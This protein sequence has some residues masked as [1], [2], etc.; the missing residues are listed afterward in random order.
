MKTTC[1]CSG[2][3]ALLF[4][5]LVQAGPS[6]TD[7]MGRQVSLEAPAERIVALAPHIVENLYSAGAGDR[8][9]GVVS[10]SDF[11]AA[12]RSLP[13]VGS[14]FA[15]SLETV[16]ALQPDLV[17]LWGSGN[18]IN[19]LANL[20]RLG[21]PVYVSEPRDFAA[22]ADSIRDFGTLAG[23]TT[24]AQA[25]AKRFERKI[26]AL[27]DRYSGGKTLRAFYQIWN[28][29]LQT[30]NGAHLI[31]QVIALCGGENVFAGLT[32]LAPRINIEAVIAA[33]PDVIIASGMDRSR[34]EWLDDWQQFPQLTAVKN[35][36][37]VY[38]D[39]DLIQ[40][41]TARIAEG[42]ATLCQR[43]GALAPHAQ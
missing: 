10:Y 39:P 38:V 3:L 1:R 16:V 8:L 27:R 31:S 12:A 36:A 23:T 40:R 43:M 24:T 13:E 35:E 37:L 22:I 26:G 34:P 18:G 20:Q 28:S 42:A 7:S 17:V 19:G 4:S 5:V 25:I 29:P 6:V 41:P 14:A 33:D 30:V 2:I 32:A 11:P 9:V 15:W 21:I